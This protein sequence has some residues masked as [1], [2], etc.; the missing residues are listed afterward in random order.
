M[1]NEPD[2]IKPA[3]LAADVPDWTGHRGEAVWSILNAAREGDIDTLRE[4]L[5]DDATLA[6][7]DYWYTT[8]LHLAVRQGHLDAVAL[9]V[10]AG[11]DLTH[12]SLY[13]SETLLT[14]AEDRGQVEVAHYLESRL[15]ERHASRGRKQPIHEAVE[16]GELSTVLELL[17]GDD[18]HRRIVNE[19]DHLGR[20]PLH[21][22]VQAGN[23][24]LVTRLFEAGAELDATG[25][26]S[27]DRLGGDGFR[28][29][30]LALWHH[31]YWRQRNDYQ[32]AEHLI[33]LGASY[34]ITIAAAL[35]DWR[36]VKKM[37]EA[38][39]GL[40]N[41][42]EAGGKRPL[43]AAAERGYAHIVSEL[44][45]HGANPNLSEGP[46]CPRGY[47]LWAAA[48]FGHDKIVRMLLDAG[49]DPNAQVESS[50]SP[51]DSAG[52]DAIR[53]RLYAHGGVVDFAS[54]F[55]RNNIDTIA[56]LLSHAPELF[57]ERI[58]EQ[59]FPMCVSFGHRDLI[60][61]LL[62]HDIR[63]PDTV[64]YC[65]TYLWQ[66]LTL[67]TL[68][69][70]HGM[71]PDLPNWQQVRPLHH[72]AA[73]GNIEAAKLFLSYGANPLAIDEEYRSTPLGWAARCGQAD[74]VHFLIERGASDQGL[75][76]PPWAEAL[77]WARR[78]GHREIEDILD[79]TTAGGEQ[80][81]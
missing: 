61:L 44:L 18:S 4:L 70:D 71:S 11:A 17:S 19:G 51:T 25:F 74:F 53:H 42:Q 68:L 34:T 46:N 59:A 35:G 26:S 14:I 60:E 65:Q 69:L 58:A 64:T 56:A 62:V 52:S 81:D 67:T 13:Q 38:D 32:M 29:L 55:H 15:S 3:E 50:G 21:Y 48:H 72:V 75:D 43:S 12:R 5:N 54:H 57:T 23:T 37:L 80:H 31:P 73:A 41:D 27:D 10:E 28:P 39:S 7:V 45:D 30:T 6:N 33:E 66:N 22:A 2:L 77:S 1:S 16:S 47:A 8:P 63:V 76:L 36:G 9:L 78:R 79:R 49:A 20:R 40:A 24:D